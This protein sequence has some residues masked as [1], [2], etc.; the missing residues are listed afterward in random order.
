MSVQAMSHVWSNSN[1][2][3]SNLLVM[4]AIANYAHADGSNAFPS[5]STIAKDSRMSRRQVVRIIK[6]LEESGELVIDHGDIDRP[7]HYRI[8]MSPPSDKMSL[9]PSDKMSPPSD[10]AMSHYPLANKEKTLSSKELAKPSNGKNPSE[11]KGHPAIRAIRSITA[12]YPDKTIWPTLIQ[13]VGEEP[14]LDRLRE[15]YQRWRL[16]GYSPTN[17]S[18]VTEWYAQGSNG[19]VNVTHSPQKELPPRLEYPLMMAVQQSFPVKYADRQLYEDAK[20]DWL[21]HYKKRDDKEYRICL[22]EVTAY[23]ASSIFRERFPVQ[24]RLD[25]TVESNRQPAQG[26]AYPTPA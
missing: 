25:G 20:R 5:L 23:E 21:E 15:C 1:Q 19:H 11:E 4:L 2:K 9:P 6:S 22:E 17:Y 24:P 16:K 13:V 12:R 7:N 3:G 14:D 8:D 18:W 10:I 26:S